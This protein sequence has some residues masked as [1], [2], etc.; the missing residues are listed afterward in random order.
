MYLLI[1]IVYAYLNKDF[2]YEIS[3]IFRYFFFPIALVSL[4]ILYLDNKKISFKI[5]S[6]VF[7]EY[8]LLIFIPIITKTGFN[9]YAYSKVGSIG[10]FNSTNE[11]GGIFTI[12]LPFFLKELINKKNIILNII[13]FIII[14]FV[15]FS[16]GSKVPVITTLLTYLLFIY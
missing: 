10:W 1:S 6:I 16:M 9:S 3:N 7:L 13:F 14:I 5:L 12:L 11:I 4:Y 8:L 2:I 15:S